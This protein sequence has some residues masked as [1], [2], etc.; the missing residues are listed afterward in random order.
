MILAE[1]CSVISDKGWA[2]IADLGWAAATG[3]IFY[4]FFRYVLGG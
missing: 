4:A 2:S 1:T 3:V